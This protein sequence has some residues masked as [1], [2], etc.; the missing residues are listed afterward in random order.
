MSVKE[1]PRSGGAHESSFRLLRVG[2]VGLISVNHFFCPEGSSNILKFLTVLAD[3]ITRTASVT[4]VGAAN[5]NTIFLDDVR[6][7]ALDD[8]KR[9]N[10]LQF[11]FL[12]FSKGHIRNYRL[13]ETGLMVVV[14][15][16]LRAWIAK[17]LN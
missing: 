17:L 13:V 8:L 11:M 5:F 3:V 16:L 10:N 12:A 9:R 7:A 14:L 6:A 15:S 1:K 2:E 4:V